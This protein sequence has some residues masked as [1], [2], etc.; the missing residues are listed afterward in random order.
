[1]RR[2]AH[3]AC[4]LK[5]AHSPKAPANRELQDLAALPYSC[6]TMWL[7]AAGAGFLSM[8][9]G[10]LGTLALQTFSEWEAR[11]TAVAKASDLARLLLSA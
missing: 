7:A 5:S 2:N 10:G 8:A 4:A 6:V 3:L 11:V 9:A 1:M